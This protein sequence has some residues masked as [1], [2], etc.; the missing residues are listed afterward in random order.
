LAIL[1]NQMNPVVDTLEGALQGTFF[2]KISLKILEW[3]QELNISSF[4]KFY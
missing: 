2:F 3:F 1:N 4:T